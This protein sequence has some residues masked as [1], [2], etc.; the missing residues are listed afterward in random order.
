MCCKTVIIFIP[1]L[2]N[3]FVNGARILAT[4]PFIEK[5]HTIFFNPLLHELARRGHEVTVITSI[6]SEIKLNNLTE[7]IFDNG[8]GNYYLLILI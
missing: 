3:V 7:I 4:F 8:V 5:S 6:S 2:L 1:V